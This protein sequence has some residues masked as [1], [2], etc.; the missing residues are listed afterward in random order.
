MIFW[1]GR[2]ACSKLEHMRF[3]HLQVCWGVGGALSTLGKKPL[4]CQCTIVEGESFQFR[5][6]VDTGKVR[7][8]QFSP[9]R[10]PGSPG[11]PRRHLDRLAPAGRAMRP[12]SA[13]SGIAC[14]L[15]DQGRGGTLVLSLPAGLHWVVQWSVHET[16]HLLRT[17]LHRCC[18]RPSPIFSHLHQ[19]VFADNICLCKSHQQCAHVSLKCVRIPMEGKSS[20]RMYIGRLNSNLFS[21]TV[22]AVVFSKSA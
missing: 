18:C 7:L 9:L 22:A 21:V 14:G 10:H 16:T 19:S 3:L 12:A 1:R 2:K 17:N 6:G 13:R 8:G 5:G 15:V 11:S 20:N 4:L